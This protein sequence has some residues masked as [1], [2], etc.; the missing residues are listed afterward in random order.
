M[1]ELPKSRPEAS[2]A[3][4]NPNTAANWSFLFSPLFGAY[5]HALNW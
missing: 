1:N 4:W 2:N 3:L 5:L